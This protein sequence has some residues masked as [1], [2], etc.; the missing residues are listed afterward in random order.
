MISKAVQIPVSE[1][2]GPTI[3]GEGLFTGIKTH[4]VRVAGCDLRCPWCDTKYAWSK[5]HAT[6]MTSE[7]ILEVCL[8][9][10]YNFNSNTSNIKGHIITLTGGNPL[11]YD[12][13]EF[14]D[15]VKKQGMEIH[16]ETQGTIW[17]DWVKKAS[18]ISIS[19]KPQAWDEDVIKRMTDAAPSQLKIV[20]FGEKDLDFAY[21]FYQKFQGIPL[22][23]QAGYDNNS[24]EAGLIDKADMFIKDKRFD[25]IVRFL[26]QM[27]RV[28]WG[29]RRGV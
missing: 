1:I 19:P 18:F 8:S 13:N 26:P 6:D 25:G 4:F 20:I 9:Q 17:K 7:E 24:G 27:H 15:L 22:I 10:G 16:I 23:I 29:N 14:C 28:I 2:I 3:Q 11:M 12:F 5:E 21:Y